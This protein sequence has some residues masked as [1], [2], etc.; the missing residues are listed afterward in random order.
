MSKSTGGFDNA[1][2]YALSANAE[3][4]P[5]VGSTGQPYRVVVLPGT[6]TVHKKELTITAVAQ[7]KVYGTVAATVTLSDDR[8]H[9]DELT[10]GYALA[11]FA[12]KN[13]G[14]GKQVTIS[15]ITV[16]GADASNYTF[17]TTVLTTADITPRP[18]TITANNL[19]KVYGDTLPDTGAVATAPERHR[20]Q[21]RSE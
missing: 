6:Y 19:S 10:L 8:I 20:R 14:T 1:G 21:L 7:N 5:T 12:D 3:T 16:S 15:G 13:V 17:D 11:V 18:L 4:N 9:G 2:I